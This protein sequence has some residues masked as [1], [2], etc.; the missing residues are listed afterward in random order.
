M[1]AH[2]GADAAD[3]VPGIRG[4]S[5]DGGTAEALPALPAV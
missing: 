4:G 2:A 5:Q 1:I 3:S